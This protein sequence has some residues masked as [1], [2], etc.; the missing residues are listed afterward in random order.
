MIVAMVPLLMASGSG[1][2]SR[3]DIGL[4]VA[5]DHREEKEAV[6]PMEQE[7]GFKA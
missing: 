1:V 2:V 7:S 4:V 6:E 3:F 5:G